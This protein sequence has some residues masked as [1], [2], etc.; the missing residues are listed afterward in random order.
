MF[1]R[2]QLQPFSD[3][4]RG[5][6]LS[7]AAI[8]SFELHYERLCNGDRGVI[9]ESDIEPVPTLPD[10]EELAEHLPTEKGATSAAW[11]MDGWRCA[12]RPS[13]PL[14]LWMPFRT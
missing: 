11:P 7:S 2:A 13:A 8:A 6:G 14:K 3:R 12:S 9:P 1:Q 4:M 5:A 10:A